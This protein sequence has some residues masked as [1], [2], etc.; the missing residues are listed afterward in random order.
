V[1]HICSRGEGEHICVIVCK[2]LITLL[3]LS[4]C[5]EGVTEDV[6]SSAHCQRMSI[7]R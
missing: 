3:P 5:R 7:I 2:V 6:P 4:G 1:N